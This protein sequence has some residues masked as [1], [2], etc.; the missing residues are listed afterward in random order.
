MNATKVGKLCAAPV[1]PMQREA[2]VGYDCFALASV[3]EDHQ[4]E[5]FPGLV[6]HCFSP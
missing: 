3:E 6:Q 1:S 2:A 4:N 5:R